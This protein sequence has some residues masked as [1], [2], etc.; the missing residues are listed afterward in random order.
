MAE[1]NEQVDFEY[2][3]EKALKQGFEEAESEGELFDLEAW[4]KDREKRRPN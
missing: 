4:K 2:N 1:E 3:E